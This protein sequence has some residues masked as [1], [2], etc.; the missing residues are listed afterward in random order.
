MVMLYCNLL[1]GPLLVL[2]TV[3]L[4]WWLL[5]PLSPYLFA[6]YCAW[7]YYDNKTRPNPST[8]RLSP[9]W[10]DASI[11]RLMRDYFPMRHT[12]A[13]PDAKFDA[14]R[15][16]LFCYH[17]HGVQS[18]GAFSMSTAA[19]GFDELFPA[20]PPTSVQTLTMNFYLPMTRENLMA[21]NCGDASA[22]CLKN[23][24][25]RGGGSSA[26][27]V[28]GGARES[29]LAHPY[30]S[31]CVLLERKGFVK[32]ALQ[33]GAALVPMWGFGEN[34]LYENMA[35]DSPTIRRWQQRIQRALT[36]APLLVAGRGVFSY[37]GGLMPRRR[38]ITVVIGDPID[39]GAA[40][41]APSAERIAQV[42]AKY[43]LA[44]K[45]LHARYKEIYDPKAQPVE[46]V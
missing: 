27:L 34:N 22:R 43:I 16:Y 6:L 35:I 44:V 17:P 29:M 5:R 9:G 39:V 2:A 46:L 20:L 23:V 3:A 15:S 7:V 42:H 26:V 28:T 10:R 4:L 25:S 33:T 1:T 24:L 30:H 14:S 45:E 38:P 36:F 19:S 18:S 41:A 11:W 37:T 12:L 32:I 21:L 13:H 31:T 8:D 40:E